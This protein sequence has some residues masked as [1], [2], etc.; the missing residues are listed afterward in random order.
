MYDYQFYPSL[1]DKFNKYLHAE[2]VA[3]MPWND[4]KSFSEVEQ[5]LYNELIDSINRVE[6]PRNE[7]AEKG[8]A[9][10]KLIDLLILGANVT[11]ACINDK[12]L[13]HV[14]LEVGEE[15]INFF[16]DKKLS[17]DIYNYL[18]GS[19]SQQFVEGLI[20]TSKGSV[21]LYGFADY[22]R[23]NVCADLK[24]TSRYNFWDYKAGLQRHLY[25]YCLNQMGCEIDTFDYVVTDFN[26]YYFETYTYL[27]KQSECYLRDICERFISFIEAN[28]DKITD[29]KIFNGTDD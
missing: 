6:R 27:P 8:I 13:Y 25:P 1:L 5:E 20:S 12:L 26:V 29:K 18:W 9:F 16:F 23:R 10:N 17:D 3:Q 11:E 7:A 28:R 19:M 15:N 4:S 2:T 22:V 14:V 24:T 21:R